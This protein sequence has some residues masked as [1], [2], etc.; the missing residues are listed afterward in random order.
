M[1]VR[2]MRAFSGVVT[3]GV[4]VLMLVVVGAAVFGVQRGFPGPGPVSI[5]WHVGAAVV[6]LGLQ[7][8]AD[9][10]NGVVSFI[11]SAAVIVVAAVLL[12]TQWWG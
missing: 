7:W 2:A 9:R 4:V 10:R 11:A 3:G 12:W 6:V 5:V 1:A 8:F